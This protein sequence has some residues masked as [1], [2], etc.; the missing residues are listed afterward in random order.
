MGHAE[1]P[2]QYFAGNAQQD[3]VHQQPMQPQPM[4]PAHV[5]SGEQKPIEMQPGAQQGMDPASSHVVA[6]PHLG[7]QPEW[8]DCQFCRQRT[9]TNVVQK[10]TG[11]Q[12]VM[13]TVLCLL[14]ICLAPLPCM[15]HWFEE[16]QWFCT[17]CKNM[18][19]TK[20]GKDTPIQVTPTPEQRVAPS[21]YN[22]GQ[23]PV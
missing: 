22:N 5:R 15:L 7:P 4:E 10:G 12:V 21:Q 8:I 14:C 19:A 16:T 17:N 18:V 23:P 6:L 2:P 3:N 1:Q 11:M 13:G 20:G 9:K